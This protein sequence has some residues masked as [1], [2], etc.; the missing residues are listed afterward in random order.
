MKILPDYLIEMMPAIEDAMRE[1]RLSVIDHAYE[2]LTRLDVDEL[3]SDDIRKKL[4]L[5]DL[6]VDNM[7]EE[8]LPN[9]KFYR[10]YPEIKHNRT[11]LN[12]LKS[13][14][15][16]GGQF[17]GLWSNEFIKKSEYNYNKIRTV[18]HYTVESE[19]DG[20]FYVSGNVTRTIV[21][22][23]DLVE[24]S[25]LTALSTDILLG[26]AMPAGY[27][28]LY[29]PWPRPTYPADAGYFYNVNMLNADRLH[30]AIDC[31]TVDYYN[32]DVPASTNYDWV[33][34]TDTPYRTPYWFDYH[35]MGDMRHEDPNL[36]LD[37]NGQI[38]NPGKWKIH[39]HGSYVNYDDEGNQVPTSPQDAHFYVLDDKC[40]I[41][42]SGDAIFAT[43]CYIRSSNRT[44]NP[45]QSQTF[46]PRSLEDV[47]EIFTIDCNNIDDI[48][49]ENK[50]DNVK[51]LYG[52]YRWDHLFDKGIQIIQEMGHIKTYKPIWSESSPVFAM[53][54]STYNSGLNPTEIAQ[55]SFYNWF[56][57]KQQSN[58][59]LPENSTIEN[60]EPPI[61]EI[62]HTSFDRPTYGRIPG[63]TIAYTRAANDN[64]GENTSLSSVTQD[65]GLYY[66]GENT[67]AE[68]DP[69]IYYCLTNIY[70]DDSGEIIVA[71]IASKYIEG[72]PYSNELYIN[73]NG[74]DDNEYCYVTFSTSEV[75]TL[76]FSTDK[77]DTDI[78]SVFALYNKV[79]ANE[80][81]VYSNPVGLSYNIL[82]IYTENDTQLDSS[83]VS[84]ELTVENNGGDYAYLLLG[85]I[86]PVIE[87]YASLEY[88]F[89]SQWKLA[90]DAEDASYVTSAGDD[91]Y[92]FKSF[93]NYHIGGS[94]KMYINLNID[95]TED[96]S[97]PLQ[98]VN[99]SAYLDYV[100]VTVDN[101]PYSFQ[102]V[103]SW[104]TLDL[105]LS[106]GDHEIIID[107]NKDSAG[108][109]GNDCG[110]VAIPKAYIDLDDTHKDL[111]KSKVHHKNAAYIRFTVSKSNTTP[112]IMNPVEV[113]VLDPY[114]NR[115]SAQFVEDLG[116]ID[117]GFGYIS[118]SEFF[119]LGYNFAPPIPVG[120][121]Y[122][123][124]TT[125][126][127]SVE[128]VE[129]GNLGCASIINQ[130]TMTE[131]ENSPFGIIPGPSRMYTTI[132][133]SSV[134]IPGTLLKVRSDYYW[135]YQFTSGSYLS[136][137]YI[138]DYY[139]SD[140]HISGSN[141]TSD[142][143]DYA[144]VPGYEFNDAVLNVN[145]S[146]TQFNNAGIKL[147]I[148]E[149]PSGTGQP[150]FYTSLNTSVTESQRMNTALVCKPGT[151][152][153]WTTKTLFDLPGDLYYI[154]ANNYIVWN[155]SHIL[156]DLLVGKT[157][158]IYYDAT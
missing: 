124:M 154:D 150:E 7:T 132:G 129:Q 139:E 53:M 85:R 61:S 68:Y 103:Y 158:T 81:Y 20:Y 50:T 72:D 89:N 8:W 148:G 114:G 118:L 131:I 116:I 45:N 105:S 66:L 102:Q 30:Y 22:G 27:T 23:Q 94:A 142:S 95:D 55:H 54:Q 34:G 65:N 25:T 3:S 100:T 115:I 62:T 121:Q 137:L 44:T 155:T 106:N 120:M 109:N 101:T 15:C 14:V 37:A 39:E 38:I 32:T 46:V 51:E 127:S 63:D 56:E 88:N 157:V 82:G 35:Y 143:T 29:I 47:D 97:L 31:N 74:I 21:H 147:Q 122:G 12:S 156:Y 141:P 6:K 111:Q 125:I 130:S 90:E 104:D 134:Y 144:L 43:P 17:E 117:V 149:Y 28:Y 64:Q 99:S 128:V 4:E 77:K 87:I 107:F 36:N 57:L 126:G 78:G 119:E 135:M 123:I 70:S 5:Y 76:W 33:N 60:N 26:Q 96:F 18:R 83:D 13:V 110:Y 73:R 40:K 113:D 140:M 91:Y 19:Y 49:K 151:N 145:G 1:L 58:I 75:H 52:P 86:N 133:G 69:T 2:L 48:T 79:G 24:D 138:P 42:N 93:S 136:N 84:I 146:I 98:I 108:Y 9:G 92:V 112:P 10:L 41:L 67:V 59:L 153:T 16:S 152:P 71:D 11:R 80:I